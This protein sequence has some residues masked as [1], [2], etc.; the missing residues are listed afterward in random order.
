MAAK[1]KYKS[2]DLRIRLLKTASE[3]ISKESM[4]KLTMR[5]LSNRVGVSRTA[6]YRHFENKD[7]LLFAIAEEGFN[8]LTMRYQKLNRDTSLDSL[9]RLQQIGLAY[10]KFAIHNPGAFRLMFGQEITQRERSEKL[11][12]D[13]RETFNE[14]LVAVKAFQEEKNITL[15][16]YSVLANYFWTTV[17]G[18]SIL[19]IDGQIQVSGENYGLP[20]L[21][22]DD[23]TDIMGSVKSMIAFSKQT[24]SNFWD[25]ILD[26]ISQKGNIESSF[27]R[28]E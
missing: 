28:Q 11:C 26:G 27:E 19:L 7:A 13:A 18:L 20:T 22:T 14:Y 6:P 24:L 12:S 23:K 15:S 5:A 3:I 17:H 25:G 1:K 16:D 8:E 4:K 10:I 21:L 9:S 2:G